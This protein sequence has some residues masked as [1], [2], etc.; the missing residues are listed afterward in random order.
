MRSFFGILILLHV[1]E[2]AE[3][4]Q[5]LISAH[6]EAIEETTRLLL[7]WLRDMQVVHPVARW[8]WQL[9]RVTHKDHLYVMTA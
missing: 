9:I 7:A 8:C 3:V 6:R 2:K 1:S 4:L 5:P